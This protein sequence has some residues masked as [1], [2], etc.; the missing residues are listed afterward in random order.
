M[1]LL[2]LGCLLHVC[3]CVSERV[4]RCIQV[5]VSLHYETS[6]DKATRILHA[7]AS[8]QSLRGRLNKEL[9]FES[10]SSMAFEVDVQHLGR[11]QEPGSSSTP[12]ASTRRGRRSKPDWNRH[13]HHLS[14]LFII[15]LRM[16]LIDSTKEVP[17]SIAWQS[18]V[19][20]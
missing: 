16:R 11:V 7:F 2:V 14:T 6:L 8:H 18:C 17:S 10:Q 5:R 19:P 12:L 1:G 9:V 13:C 3:V 4:R 15:V 20:A